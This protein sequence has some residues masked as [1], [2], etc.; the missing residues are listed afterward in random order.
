MRLIRVGAPGAER[1]AALAD[2]GS[3]V[4]LSDVVDDFDERFFGPGGIERIRPVVAERIAAGRV[5]DLG[6][7]RLGAPTR[8]PANRDSCPAAARSATTGRIRSSPPPPKN[9]SLKSSTTSDRST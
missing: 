5:R 6:D 3:Y 7:E 8:S 4:D 2:E 9:C 1:P